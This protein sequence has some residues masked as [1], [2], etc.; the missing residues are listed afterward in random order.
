MI[1]SIAYGLLVLFHQLLHIR[2]RHTLAQEELLLL[3]GE[4]LVEDEAQNEILV[5]ARIHLA[6][7]AVGRF[8][9]YRGEL[10]LAHSVPFRMV[11]RS[12]H[13]S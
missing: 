8:P 1:L 6:P 4:V 3:L 7:H 10:L 2:R 11:H 12:F 9:D 5:L 13:Y